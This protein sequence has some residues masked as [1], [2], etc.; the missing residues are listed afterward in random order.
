VTTEPETSIIARIMAT[1]YNRH[2][3]GHGPG[4][5]YAGEAIESGDGH[6]L[7]VERGGSQFAVRVE[8]LPA[9]TAAAPKTLG[10][11]WAA[12]KDY[13]GERIDADE[14]VRKGFTEMGDLDTARAHGCLVSAN[15]STLAMMRELEKQP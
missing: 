6:A 15:R 2:V 1:G 5:D 12:L 4:G 10:Q 14:A 3:R 8:R 7:Y 11:C 13:L 9:R